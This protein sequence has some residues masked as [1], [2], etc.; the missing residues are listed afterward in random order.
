MGKEATENSA[1]ADAAAGVPD[2]EV[3]G[4]LLRRLQQANR[5]PIALGPGVGDGA[6]MTERAATPAPGPLPPS[7]SGAAATAAQG[8][9]R[10][11]GPKPGRKPAGPGGPGGA[12]RRPGPGPGGGRVAKL[13]GDAQG[14][15]NAE[16]PPGPKPVPPPVFAAP[17]VPGTAARD[18]P[19]PRLAGWFLACVALPLILLAGFLWGVVQDQYGSTTAFSVRREEAAPSAGMLAGL[20]GLTQGSSSDTDILYDFLVSQD[21]AE[22]IDRRF[23]LSRLYPRAAP[24]GWPD[25]VFTLAAEASI[26]RRHAVWLRMIRIDY[27]QGEG[28]ISLT[29]RAGDPDTA[30]RLAQAVVAE[31][32]EMINALS[33]A[34]RRDAMSVARDELARAEARLRG[35]RTAVTAF[36][37]SHQLV[38]PT[39]DLASQMGV[40]DTLNEE[41]ATLMVELDLLRKTSR[42][43]DPR[44]SAREA[45]LKVI[46]NRIAAERS[47][48]GLGGGDGAETVPGGYPAVMAEYEGLEVDREFAEQSWLSARAAL[49]AARIAAGRQSR[50]LATHV[51]P[52]LAETAEYPRRWRI[53]AITTFLLTLGWA[54]GALVVW[55]VRE[56]AR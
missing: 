10:K 20:V 40:I 8:P 32:T 52:G 37:A 4:S 34:A 22:R 16:L 18:L 49:D 43:G 47:K 13:P 25:P 56:G 19:R 29:V 39:D 9:V 6:R 14:R 42:S 27:D 51:A 3:L 26:E 55:S 53:M 45:K 23:D 11:P 5:V 2:V 41:L 15:R 36:R 21:L 54:T 7:P 31:C 24:P 38:D 17:L 30:R 35:A 33:D 1:R 46:E 12:G 48:L 28:V 44:I 50:Y